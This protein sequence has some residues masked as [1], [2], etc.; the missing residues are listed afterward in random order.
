ML[1]LNN[2]TDRERQKINVFKNVCV[3]ISTLSHDPKLKVGTIIITDDFRD[4]C[5]I[6]LNGNYTG[7]PNSRDS[8]EVGMSG[9]LHSEENALFH[10]SKPYE[11]RDNLIMI[12]THKPCPMCA[13]RIVN[14]G[15][16]RVLY[17][18]EYNALGSATDTIFVHSNIF[19]SSIHEI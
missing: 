19:C 13:K 14:S 1:D 16:K 3:E 9:F 15:I 2:I 8:D 11:L 5:A 18:N 10:L 6:G 17:I 4:V 12:C 7:G